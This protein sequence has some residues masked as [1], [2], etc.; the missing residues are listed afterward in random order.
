[1]CVRAQSEP[2]PSRSRQSTVDSSGSGNC[3]QQER[4]RAQG[5]GFCCHIILFGPHVAARTARPVKTCNRTIRRSPSRTPSPTAA[6]LKATA[7]SKSQGCHACVRPTC[8]APS[9]CAVP[10]SGRADE[11]SCASSF[12]SRPAILAAVTPASLPGTASSEPG[13]RRGVSGGKGW[14]KIV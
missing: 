6:A 2:P 11:H 12:D 1:V 13:L 9:C 5:C 3:S 14:R 7:E 10:S 8:R 4:E